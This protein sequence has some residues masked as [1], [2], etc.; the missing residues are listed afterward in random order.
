LLSKWLYP[1]SS[2]PKPGEQLQFFNEFGDLGVSAFAFIDENDI[3]APIYYSTG[4]NLQ[5]LDVCAGVISDRTPCCLIDVHELSVV[6]GR[7]AIANTGRDEALIYSPVS[8]AMERRVLDSYRRDETAD[9]RDS[10]MAIDR[11]HLNQV[12]EGISGEAWG[13][14][15]HVRGQQRLRN[16]F[17]KIL[18]AHGDGGV[19]NLDSGL[20]IDL[21]LHAPHSVRIINGE[22]WL[23]NSGSMSVCVY[24]RDWTLVRHFSSM[25]WGRGLAVF[26]ASAYVGISPI[27]RRYRSVNGNSISQP[28][29][30][31]VN[32]VD[33]SSV[34]QGT[35]R[36]I[37]QVNN[38]YSVSREVALK[39]LDL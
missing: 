14:V 36:H 1:G 3:G 35:L 7:I 5:E 6:Q 4:D 24:S 25:G 37:E 13:L 18:K 33:G 10:S 15:H 11:F 31:V 26:G 8:G 21:G 22:Y 32:V 38:V 17:G 29:I 9:E 23:M 2:T 19:I 28:H 39:L 16:V 12:F 20:C 27:R 30:E 34:S